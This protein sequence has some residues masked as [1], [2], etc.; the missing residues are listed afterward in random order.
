MDFDYKN[1]LIFGYSRSGKAVEKVL[2][3]IGSNY[4]IYDDK[5]KID[6]G[7]YISK[8]TRRGLS[9]FDLIILSPGVSIYHKKI[10]LAEQL[11]IKVISELEFGFWFTSADIIAVTGTNGKTTTTFLINQVLQLAGF[12]SDAYGNIGNPLSC[13]YKKDLDYIVCEVSSFQLESTD[14]FVGSIGI[15][16]NV[17]PDHIDRHKTFKNYCECKKGLFKNC[18]PDDYA[19]IGNNSAYSV[20]ISKDIAGKVLCFGKN[21]EEVVAKDNKIYINNEKVCEINKKLMEFTFIDNIL[22]VISVMYILK[23]DF[24]LINKIKLPSENEHRLECFLRHNGITYINDSK[25]TNPHAVKNAVETIKGNIVLLVGGYDKKLSF[26][27]LIGWLPS[28]VVSV[29][30]FGSAGKRI[31]RELKILGKNFVYCKTLDK[32]IDCGMDIL[33]KGDTLLL[34]P[35][36]SS[37]DEFTSYEER[38]KF[39]KNKV[40]SRL[41]L[42]VQN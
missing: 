5:I 18:S 4:K 42:S 17:S 28:N 16:L 9:N 27:E 20:K 10:K 11:G 24:D 36:C 15:L 21:N 3:D 38:G 39:F 22:A 1:I 8:L 12:K 14:K 32:A 37:F 23:I 26:K 29:V 7:L 13:A 41:N 31:A 2:K 19:V 25:A 40:L 33:V 34:S 35:A 6:G 30:S